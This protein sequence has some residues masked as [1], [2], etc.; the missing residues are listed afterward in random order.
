MNHQ[1][2]TGLPGTETRMGS[3]FQ[4]NNLNFF[5]ITGSGVP[6]F[7]WNWNW[8]HSNFFKEPGREVLLRNEE[9]T[10]TSKYPLVIPPFLDF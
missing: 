8:N 9:Q 2:Q 5:A 4:N 1:F 6:F 10:N 3:D 7:L